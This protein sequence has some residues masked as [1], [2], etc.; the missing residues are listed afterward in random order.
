[1][2]FAATTVKL[3]DGEYVPWRTRWADGESWCCLFGG[4]KRKKM[5][6]IVL[7]KLF[8][9]PCTFFSALISYFYGLWNVKC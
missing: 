5:M 7:G 6:Y 3:P 1:M 9:G 4:K 8:D 2:D